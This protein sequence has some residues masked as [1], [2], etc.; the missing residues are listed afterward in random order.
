MDA[1]HGK[2]RLMLIHGPPSGHGDGH[3]QVIMDTSLTG[4]RLP[5]SRA[6]GPFKRRELLA[7]LTRG[8]TPGGNF[9]LTVAEER[10]QIHDQLLLGDIDIRPAARDLRA[11]R[12]PNRHEGHAKLGGE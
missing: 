1:L 2:R 4:E 5:S 12:D 7:Q 9:N 8:G 11:G 6:R 3:D 10:F